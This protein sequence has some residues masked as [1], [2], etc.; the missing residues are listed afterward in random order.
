MEESLKIT[1]FLK[2]ILSLVISQILIKIFGVVYSLYMTN[3]SGFGDE[4][5]A[6]YMSGY[7]IYALLL[8]IS[9]IGVPNAISKI[10]S[11]KISIKDYTNSDRIFKIS[12][13]LF[14]IIGFLGC[15]LLFMFSEFIAEEVLQIPETK[16][17]LMVL[18]PA[19]FFVSVSSVIRGYCNGENKI[20][21]TAKSQF[22]EQVLK[23]IFTITFVE[24]VSKSS[25]SSK[26]VMAAVAN[27]ATTM[28]T[29]CSLIFIFKEYIKIKKRNIYLDRVNFPRER[30]FNIVKKVLV[31]SIPIT[32]SAI[33]SSLGKNVDSVTV[34][35]ILKEILG[36]EIAIAKYGILSSKVDILIALPL[37]FNIAIST[38][39][40]PEISRKRA[41]NDLDG[42]IK[43]IE[44]SILITIIIGI[45][46]SFGM[47]F[48]SGRIFDLLYPRANEGAKLLSLASF[49]IIFSLLVQTLNGVLQGLGKNNVPVYASIIG[50]IFKILSN[51]ILIPINGIYEKGAIIGNIL[52]NMISFIIV[53]IVLKKNIKIRLNILKNSIKPII[54]SIIMIF[55][56]ENIYKFLYIKNFNITFCTIISIFSAVIIY[57]F[58]CFSMKIINKNDFF[59]KPAKC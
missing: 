1:D 46:C 43:K 20:Y 36:E 33:L 53:V 14:S 13:F 51:I 21:I 23:S 40:I 9:S 6:I 57:V 29:F 26:E 8:T 41:V 56:S 44:T 18:S 10:I 19:I 52:S 47:Y 15:I 28:A 3:K 16:L 55:V 35:R 5:N 32:T 17:S 27:F 7:Q 42:I 30:I 54:A 34:V 45:P 25:K 12:V 4:G 31:I 49:S 37:S 39:L 24:I 58:C 22:F 59:E 11:E 38:A 2:G 48:Y 50:L